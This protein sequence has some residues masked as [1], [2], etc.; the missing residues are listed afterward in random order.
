MSEAPRFGKYTIVQRIGVGG[1]AEVLQGRL[2]GL[3][4]LEKLVVL[5]RILPQHAADPEFVQ[6]FLDEAR[7]AANLNHANIIQ[8]YEVGEAEGSPY[9]CTEYV[10]GPTL[11]VLLEQARRKGR[12]ELGHAAKIISGVCAGLYYA[13]HA[14]D[15][16]GEPLKLTHRDVIPPN[17]LVSEEGVPKL[18]DF[19]MAKAR[20]KLMLRFLAPEVLKGAVV[21]RRVDIFAAAACLYEATTGQPVFSAESDA[22]LVG[23]VMQG[24]IAAPSTLVRGFPGEL[25]S[26]LM[27]ALAPDPAKRC[28]SALELREALEDFVRGGKYQSS[29][30]AVARWIAELFP[31]LSAGSAATGTGLFV[32]TATPTPVSAVPV[33]PPPPPPEALAEAEEEELCELAEGAAAPTTGAAACSA[34]SETAQAIANAAAPAGERAPTSGASQG[35]AAAAPAGER[36]P[37]SGA[38]QRADGAHQPPPAQAEAKGAAVPA[39]GAVPPAAAQQPPSAGTM[40]AG[41]SF[42]AAGRKDEVKPEQAAGPGSGVL[43]A[44]RRP[45][46]S[47]TSSAERRRA[48]LVQVVIIGVALAAGALAARM[49]WPGTAPSKAPASPAPAP[50]A[51]VVPPMSEADARL[52]GHL[53]GAE[54]LIREKRFGAARDVLDDAREVK[55]TD[56]ALALRLARV[57]DENERAGAIHEARVALRSNEPRAALE[58]A[59]RAYL[60]AP[61]DRDAQRLVE[62]ARAQLLAMGEALPEA[63]AKLEPT[64]A[65]AEPSTGAKEPVKGEPVADEPA[66]AP[67]KEPAKSEP[68]KVAANGLLPRLP[69]KAPAKVAAK[70]EP[71]PREPIKAPA[72][73]AAK[74]EPVAREPIKA[75]A[76]AKPAREEKRMRKVAR[77]E[78]IR[79]DG[80]KVDPQEPGRVEPVKAEP[81]LAEPER[82]ELAAPPPAPVLAVVAQP[83]IAP[84][85]PA[86]LPKDPRT[87]LPKSYRVKSPEELARVCLNIEGEAVS[88]AAISSEV[89]GGVTAELQR[90]LAGLFGQYKAVEFYPQGIY[91][92]LVNEASQG[93]DRA[94]IAGKI[95]DAHATGTFRSWASR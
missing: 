85:R 17:I 91:L 39:T 4:G 23:V 89:A 15:A 62:T 83:A 68:V 37:T 12:V 3:G 60:R 58:A 19:G 29:T 31:E 11:A 5:K 46:S 82:V 20:V 24:E 16:T 94:T 34:A 63:V 71:V 51:A 77:A 78:P 41:Q 10:R 52:K 9:V 47:P 64:P 32:V 1:M 44:E 54:Q 80:A 55:S 53:D 66:K 7:R 84:G 28:Q 87:H 26:V 88:A 33:R 93:R 74:S 56:T 70:S 2:S 95:K 40:P 59:T 48:L 6:S 72:K 57:S 61:D 38:S 14:M 81:V 69:P 90:E 27:W 45:D 18:L 35:V 76:K 86:P 22:E 36:G 73:V 8:L 49:P 21:D 65:G 79:A 30:T 13:H 75:P 43:S 50:L 25:E 42:P 92:L 67:A